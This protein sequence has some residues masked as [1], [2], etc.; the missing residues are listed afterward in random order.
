[1]SFFSLAVPFI[2]ANRKTRYRENNR[3]TIDS[4]VME[5]RPWR[6]TRTGLHPYRHACL[7]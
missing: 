7:V 5:G 3:I 6:G 2:A 1:M 4:S